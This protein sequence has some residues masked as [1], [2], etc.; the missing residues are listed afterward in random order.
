MMKAINTKKACSAR[1][2][3]NKARRAYDFA[4]KGSD[5]ILIAECRLALEQA[6]ADYIDACDKLQAEL[7]KVQHL[8]RERC[9]DAEAVLAMLDE[10]TEYLGITKKAMEG[11]S[12]WCN[13][14]AQKFAKAYKYTPYAT[15]FGAKFHNGTWHIWDICRY[16]CNTLRFDATLP[17]ET[18]KAIVQKYERF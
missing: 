6:E 16:E 10:Y 7:N 13:Y 18:K 11:I 3:R 17:D 14:H 1:N 15:F 12:M 9:I 4:L 2:A 8:C 5:D